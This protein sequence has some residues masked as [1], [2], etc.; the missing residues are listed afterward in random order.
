MCHGGS[1]NFIFAIL[2]MIL[3]STAFSLEYE[4]VMELDSPQVDQVKR[5]LNA[6]DGT[7]TAFGLSFY[8]IKYQTKNVLGETVPASGMMIVPRLTLRKEFA[9]VVYHHGTST[10]KNHVPSNPMFRETLLNGAIFGAGGYV[11]V[12]PDYVGLGDS[13]GLH[14]FLHVETQGQASADLIEESRKVASQLGVRLTNQLLLTGYSQGGHATMSTHWYLEKNLSFFDRVMN[15]S[16]VTASAPM[17]GPY[18][19][20][21]SSVIALTK[22]AKSTTAYV[23]LLTLSMNQIYGVYPDLR[24]LYLA[25][26]DTLI[27]QVL[28][29]TKTLDQVTQA[30][31]KEPKDILQPAFMSG[32]QAD[33]N[34]PFRKVLA[35]NDV[36][37]WKARAPI[38]LYHGEADV[39]VPFT[40][41]EVAARQMAALGSKIDVVNVGRY[42]DHH[43]AVFPAFIGTRL[44]FDSIRRKTKSTG[45]TEFG[46]LN[47]LKDLHPF[48]AQ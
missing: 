15:R 30:L 16:R 40:N 41:A 2:T 12:A 4:K 37:N 7:K 28:D 8:K 44:W 17:A 20:S 14:P 24:D 10:H 21:D 42:L 39:D 31:P 27:P 5:L 6:D 46:F 3:P 18:D 32:V 33:P 25:P 45:G 9:V 11:V 34:H 48:L 36:D 1:M 35:L 38:R 47:V 43:T 29:G 19:L 22:P 23:A 13:P 26:Y